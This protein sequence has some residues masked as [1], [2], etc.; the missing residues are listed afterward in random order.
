[1]VSDGEVKPLA[2]VEYPSVSLVMTLE[3]RP[4]PTPASPTYSPSDSPTYSPP[5]SPQESAETPP[6]EMVA[7]QEGGAPLSG[8]KRVHAIDDEPSTPDGVV[9]R[10]SPCDG[11]DPRE[12]CSHVTPPT[13][14]NPKR[15]GS[16]EPPPV[17]AK[18][19]MRLRGGGIAPEPMRFLADAA[20]GSSGAGPLPQQSAGLDANAPVLE[21]G[22]LDSWPGVPRPDEW[23]QLWQ[24]APD[25]QPPSPP[26]T[27][28]ASPL[29]S[30]P[31]SPAPSA[32]PSPAVSPPP[33]PTPESESTTPAG[34][35][36]AGGVGGGGS[37]AR[38]ITRA[39]SELVAAASVGAGAVAPVSRR[40]SAAV[41]A[42]P[43]SDGLPP[44]DTM[45][46]TPATP[47]DLAT[48]PLGTDAEPSSSR[49][50]ASARTPSLGY[51][52]YS[53]RHPGAS[54]WAS[55][56]SQLTVD[57]A[58]QHVRQLERLIVDLEQKVV[59]A[60]E[61]R[62]QVI[63][64][65]VRRQVEGGD[66]HA[67]LA[68][69]CDELTAQCQEERSAHA[70]S[71]ARLLEAGSSHRK[72]GIIL[73]SHQLAEDELNVKLELMKRKVTGLTNANAILDRRRS[74][75]SDR[76]D[77]LAAELTRTQVLLEHSKQEVEAANHKAAE[78][79][80]SK[81]EADIET[82]CALADRD[83]AESERGQ[84][85][86]E[87]AD[88]AERIL[89]LQA[90]RPARGSTSYVDLTSP[91][92]GEVGWTEASGRR[93][94]GVAVD[95]LPI[96]A[97][98]ERPHQLLLHGGVTASGGSY[99]DAAATRRQDTPRQAPT[100][101]RQ[102]SPPRQLPRTSSPLPGRDGPFQRASGAP[103]IPFSTLWEGLPQSEGW[104][105]ELKALLNHESYRLKALDLDATL[106]FVDKEIVEPHM[107]ELLD[108]KTFPPETDNMFADAQYYRALRVRAL[109][110]S[111]SRGR[112]TLGGLADFVA[113]PRQ[114]LEDDLRDDV[115]SAPS[116]YL[117]L[118]V[119]SAALLTNLCSDS[120]W[121]AMVVRCN[122][123]D[124]SANERLHRAFY[125]MSAYTKRES[126]RVR[127]HKDAVRY[128]RE[129]GER[130][131]I[132]K[133]LSSADQAK[134]AA[135]WSHFRAHFANEVLLALR[136]GA[137]WML[138]LTTLAARLARQPTSNEKSTGHNRLYGFI[139]TA[140]N[141]LPL[142]D[143]PLLHADAL[144]FKM[145]K[146]FEGAVKSSANTDYDNC[147]T[148]SS[149]LDANAVAQRLLDAFIKMKR[150]PNLTAENVWDNEI[151]RNVLF[152]R[153]HLCLTND[154]DDPARG[155]YSAGKFNQDWLMVEAEVA[156]GETDASEL[157]IRKFALRRIGPLESALQ[158]NRDLKAKKQGLPQ[159]TPVRTAAAAVKDEFDEFA[160][161]LVELPPLTS[162]TGRGVLKTRASTKQA[163]IAAAAATSS[164]SSATATAAA[165]ARAAA[166]AA[167]R[168][169]PNG[170]A[171]EPRGVSTNVPPAYAPAGRS[172][173]APTGK[174]GE[175]NETEWTEQ[176]WT[177]VTLEWGQLAGAVVD[178][179]KSWAYACAARARPDDTSLKKLRTEPERPISDKQRVWPDDACSYC[180][181]RPKASGA[182]AVPTHPNAWFYGT[183]DGK[184]NPYRCKCFK[185]YL[186]EG[187]EPSN[188]SREKQFLRAA[189]QY[190]ERQQRT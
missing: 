39:M 37:A 144:F 15:P 105:H 167:H 113:D 158:R 38:P 162:A 31:G 101:S 147:T 18:S 96:T 177:D 104:R 166:V 190:R 159:T 87:A 123:Y 20:M 143:N 137:E 6:E 189:L 60:D 54:P 64:A 175:P 114:P 109:M 12:R 188:T 59:E 163:R 169:A 181:F 47:H 82:D 40:P 5:D 184:H 61:S 134:S 102:Y 127:E 90:A 112:R 161:E 45:L 88:M 139:R 11:S 131:S 66:S 72:Q 180:H 1:M 121:A 56:D 187:G 119:P 36:E 53:V 19:E 17:R 142:H 2:C 94:R 118:P 50:P 75:D 146:S 89:E 133:D 151:D 165:N 125:T 120:S 21:G 172:A 155:Q 182:E 42:P 81:Q 174:T 98:S 132:P 79:L 68:A 69:H 70:A 32:P 138:I 156:A 97:R 74:V 43:A 129:V 84:L 135:A 108:N 63:T 76:V 71:K 117:D 26:D 170:A 124:H 29:P 30:P 10:Q 28:P 46:P 48:D 157:D 106:K 65:S 183:G 171:P 154:V 140:I 91:P 22:V 85:E 145:D 122:L 55:D 93:S 49:E 130:L 168:E 178:G 58:N 141:D 77:E 67:S 51:L 128:A 186:A 149:T 9:D 23:L 44:D 16:D 78:N 3:P 136:H 62:R 100:S 173:A 160:D 110:K 83:K 25:S 152:E 80:V 73:Q 86:A 185:R 95:P 92:L 115:S 150:D 24:L 33:S 179:V 148:R 13:T 111:S 27:P 107:D 41:A 126:Y 52:P 164:V 4:A 153:F 176:K 8:A 57:A 116:A 35:A 103:A 7:M 34:G 99:R 14:R